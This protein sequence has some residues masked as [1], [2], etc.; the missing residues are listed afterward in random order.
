MANVSE[1]DLLI[2][3]A[4]AHRA[5]HSAEHNPEQGRLHGYCIVCGIP[6]PCETAQ[7]F[8]FPP[9]AGGEGKP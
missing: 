5:C 9:A 7:F 2:A 6:W 8:L 1:V 3:A 4:T